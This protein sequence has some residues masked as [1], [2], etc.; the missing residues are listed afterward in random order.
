M[1]LTSV[2]L[3]RIFIPLKFFINKSSYLIEKLPL[4]THLLRLAKS[5]ALTIPS[6]VFPAI[7]NPTYPSPS[8]PNPT[9]DGAFFTKI[10]VFIFLAA[11]LNLET[12]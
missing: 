11:S 8:N 10:V 2:I 12:F 5:F 9:Y 7:V 4:K 6:P 3:Q 1:F